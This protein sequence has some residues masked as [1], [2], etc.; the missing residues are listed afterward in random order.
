MADRRYIAAQITNSGQV[1]QLIGYCGPWAGLLFSWAIAHVDDDGRLIGNPDQVRHKILGRYL[2]VV[3]EGDVAE[4]LATMNDLDLVVWYEVIGAPLERYLYFPKFALHQTL[5]ADRYGQSRFPPPPRWQPE[6]GHPYTKNPNLAKEKA[7]RD[8][9]ATVRVSKR[10]VN[11]RDGLG[12]STV[13]QPSGNHSAAA[14]APFSDQSA[15]DPQP[16][17]N[18]MGPNGDEASR[19]LASPRVTSRHLTSPLPS[20]EPERLSAGTDRS[21]DLDAGVRPPRPIAAVVAA[22]VGC[23]TCGHAPVVH[24]GPRDVKV[25][26]GTAR[27][28]ECAMT[29]CL[30]DAYQADVAA[31]TG[32][33]TQ[34]PP[35]PEVVTAEP[36]GEEGEPPIPDEGEPAIP[37]APARSQ[38]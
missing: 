24:R 33:E 11:A 28:G 25:A 14:G 21:R 32:P 2:P 9:R 10:P 30:C 8:R 23:A 38:S 37:D 19:H 3:S 7:Q 15:P 4:F 31:A 29:N 17:G 16:P 12:L 26:A 34:V 1:A 22:V 5:R 36:E 20:A 35:A 18:Q 6:E 27:E 13:G